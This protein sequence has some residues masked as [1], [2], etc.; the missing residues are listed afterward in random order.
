MIKPE[1]PAP[2]PARVS[3]I[4][5]VLGS[6]SAKITLIEYGDFECTSC[7]QAYHA[8]KILLNR[9]GGDLRFVFR[10]FPLRLAHPHAELAAEAAETAGAQHKFWPMHDLLFENQLHLK[11]KNLRSYAEKLELD[12]L[13]YD[14]EIDDHTYLQRIQESIENGTQGN[15]RSTPAFFVNGVLHDVS[16]DLERLD[17]AIASELA[18]RARS[19]TPPAIHDIS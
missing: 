16:F 10:H 1:S 8:V 12:L 5:H 6:A 3:Q 18:H 19:K 11:E 9:F 15:I 4:D 17:L 14:Q 7:G 13:R 2:F